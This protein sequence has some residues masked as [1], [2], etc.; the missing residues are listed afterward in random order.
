MYAKPKVFF[1][2]FLFR[3]LNAARNWFNLIILDYRLDGI[4]N[5]DSDSEV[6]EKTEGHRSTLK[7][8]DWVLFK[9]DAEAAQLALQVRQKWHSLFLRRMKSSNKSWTPHRSVKQ[10]RSTL[11]YKLIIFNTIFFLV[12]TS[13]LW[14]HCESNSQRC[15]GWRISSKSAS[16]SG[17][18]TEADTLQHRSPKRHRRWFS[19]EK[20][21]SSTCFE[22]K[23]LRK[24]F[25]VL[26]FLKKFFKTFC[27]FRPTWSTKYSFGC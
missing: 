8:D 9:V 6:E 15:H 22:K 3:D 20:K 19:R 14:C 21:F 2:F 5:L 13:G 11:F 25:I 17:N 16:T 4:T 10:N 1:D 18:R 24:K 23:F 7:I 12:P 26:N 27:A